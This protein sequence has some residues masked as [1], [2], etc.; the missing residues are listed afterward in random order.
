[1][2]VHLAGRD[3]L[4]TKTLI[5]LSGCAGLSAPLLFLLKKLGCL[6]RRPISFSS[7]FSAELIRVF[8]GNASMKKR[9]YRTISVPK[10]APA[11]ALLVSIIV[12]DKYFLAQ[13]CYYFLTYVL[14]AQKNC[15]IETVLLSTHNTC[16]G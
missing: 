11:Q 10:N 12:L 15:L 13:K 14:G 1:M 2:L 16:F 3:I 7:Y 6:P 9:L 4:I 8:D 5:R